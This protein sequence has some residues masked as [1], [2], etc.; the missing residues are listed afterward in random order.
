MP[1]DEHNIE[2][3][4]AYSEKLRGLAVGHQQETKQLLE[5]IEELQSDVRQLLKE[6]QELR[7]EN[8]AKDA[9][10]QELEQR[11]ADLQRNASYTVNGD[12]IET[13][14]VSQQYL[15]TARRKTSKLKSKFIDYTNQLDLW[16]SNPVISM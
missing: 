15:P 10:I 12:Y 14:H 1:T 7:A 11:I 6:K 4:L 16:T 2:S 3:H 13:Q 5:N 8:A 9:K